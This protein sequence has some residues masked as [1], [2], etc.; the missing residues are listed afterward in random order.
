MDRKEIETLLE[1]LAG[2]YEALKG[3]PLR[4]DVCGGAALS[5]MGLV[6][7][8]TKDIDLIAPP[9]LPPQ[10]FEAAGIVGREFGLPEDWINQ[11]PK[12]LAEMG[13][14]D[15]FDERAHKKRYGKHLT[16]CFASRLDQIFFKTYASVDRA[17][18]H[19]DDLLALEPTTEELMDAARWCMQHDVSDEFR[20]QLRSMFRQLGFGDASE[21]I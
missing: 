9:E 19:V 14:P 21:S 11:G 18:Y 1:K 13:L 12:E 16:A 4:I 8:T 10:F 17:G 5:V 6:D 3:P 2:V 7:R 20:D 15:G